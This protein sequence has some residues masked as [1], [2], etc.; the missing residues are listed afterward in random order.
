MKVK[1]SDIPEQEIVNLIAWYVKEKGKDIV[2]NTEDGTEI[3]ISAHKR[4]KDSDV[5]DCPAV[6]AALA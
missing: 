5:I 4:K 6:C 2:I 3:E 1:Y